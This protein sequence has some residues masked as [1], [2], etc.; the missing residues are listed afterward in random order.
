MSETAHPNQYEGPCC[1]CGRTVLAG[2]DTFEKWGNKWKPLHLACR[3]EF[4]QKQKIDRLQ[5][6][7]QG[8]GKR[9]QRARKTLRELE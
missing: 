6:W 9:A 1:H 8:T 5:Y 4:K 2:G 7:A 3:A